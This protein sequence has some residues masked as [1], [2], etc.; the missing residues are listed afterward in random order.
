MISSSGGGGGG[1]GASGGF[2]GVGVEDA[3]PS[4]NSHK[5]MSTRVTTGSEGGG[6]E[7]VRRGVRGQRGRAGGT[8]TGDELIHTAFVQWIKC[9]RLHIRVRNGKKS[10]SEII[11]L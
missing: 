4:D 2:G 10:H 8:C 7:R 5:C 3:C 1:S 9:V 11:I 6:G